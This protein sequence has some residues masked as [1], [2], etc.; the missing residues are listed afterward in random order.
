M[1]LVKAS[2]SRLLGGSIDYAG[3]FPPASLD[4]PGA[5]SGYR[6]AVE[7]AEWLVDLFVC[8]A[9]RAREAQD[10]ALKLLGD[11][12]DPSAP[13]LHLAAIGKPAEAADVGQSLAEDFAALKSADKVE[14]EAFEVRLPRNE[15]SVRSLKK[16]AEKSGYDLQTFVEFGW[17]EGFSEAMEMA[18]NTWEEVGFKARTGGVT[19]D[20]FP[21]P[22][23]LAEFIVT[24][25]SLEVPYKFTAGLHEPLRHFDAELGINRFGFLN[26]LAASCLAESNALGRK[27][28]QEILESEDASQFEFSDEGLV[29]FGCQVDACTLHGASGFGSCSIEEPL[30]GLERLGLL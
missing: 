3:L 22:E 27:C 18:A 15:G 10:E 6:V 4:M 14:V 17:E 13:V 7:S 5:I 24:A 29:A 30:E 28:V 9:G 1:V 20:L 23:Q 2:L 25:V 21:S 19:A 16:Q 8:P 26:V 11:D 12:Y